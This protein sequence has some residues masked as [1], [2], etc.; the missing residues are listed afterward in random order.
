MLSYQDPEQLSSRQVAAV[1]DIRDLNQV[2][3]WRRNLDQVGVGALGVRKQGRPSMDTSNS[4]QALH[5]ENERLRA[6]MAYLN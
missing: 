2:V 1:Y 6:E 3:V 4:A 5:E